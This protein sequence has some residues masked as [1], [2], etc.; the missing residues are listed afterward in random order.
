MGIVSSL[1]I[2]HCI[3]PNVK[4]DEQQ[5]RLSRGRMSSISSVKGQ[6]FTEYR[7]SRIQSDPSITTSVSSHKSIFGVEKSKSK[8]DMKRFSRAQPLH[9]NW[10]RD[11]RQSTGEALNRQSYST[12]LRTA[13]ESRPSQ[14]P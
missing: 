13:I 2:N 4:L 10:G 1:Y 8:T 12:H 7:R 14:R 9:P 6:E 3:T 11:L 5:R